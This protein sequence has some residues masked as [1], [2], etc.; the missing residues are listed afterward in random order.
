MSL[1][2]RKTSVCRSKHIAVAY[3]R[4]L[5]PNSVRY[6]AVSDAPGTMTGW[7]RHHGLDMM[8]QLPTYAVNSPIKTNAMHATS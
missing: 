5:G 1:H 4:A 3:S 7:M 8:Q 2:P 6:G